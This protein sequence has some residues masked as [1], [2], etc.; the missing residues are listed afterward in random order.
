MSE[1]TEWMDKWGPEK[2]IVVHDTRTGMKGMLVIDNTARGMG[3]GGCR[4]APDVTL[5]DCFRLARTMT[6]KWA[7]ADVFLGGAK[8]AIV[9][10]PKDPNKEEIV[11]AFVRAIRKFLPDEYVFGNDMGFSGKDE[12]IVIDECGGDTRVAIGTPAALGG[13]PYDEMGLTG[14]GVAE[15]TGVAVEYCG[16]NLNEASIAIQGLGAVGSF[17]AR[18][19][20]Q[21]GAKIVAISSIEGALYDPNGLNIERLCR[22]KEECGDSAINEYAEAKVI[23]TGEEVKLGVD[24]LIPAAGGDV[25]S[26][27]NA[28][29]VKAKLIVEGANF[30]ITNGAERIL[31]EKGVLIVPDI[32][33]NAGAA[34]GAGLAMHQ[35]YSY[36]GIE[37]SEIYSTIRQKITSNVSLVLN[38]ARKRNRSPRQVALEI[39][40]ER[41]LEAMKV[42]GRIPKP[43]S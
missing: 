10:D 23:P 21:K 1:V 36:C 39:A 15:V 9:V 12:A 38:E 24:I 20:S 43:R 13:L 19:L 7:I 34:I 5:W 25:I 32:V 35:R 6:W 27:E 14:Y 31:D 22:L 16:L 40:Q 42:K 30:P 28:G 26:E 18:Y 8:A 3:K 33:A 11:R 2:I 29:D 17:T 4:I 37:Q 41:V